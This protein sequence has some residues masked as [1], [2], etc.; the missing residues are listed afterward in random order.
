MK[1]IM[2]V[3]KKFPISLD[4]RR[5]TTNAEFYVVDGDNGNVLEITLTDDSVPVDLSDCLVLAVFSK[6]DGGVAEQDNLGNGITVDGEHNN[7]ITIELY[8]SSMSPGL[9]ECE[10]Q[11]YSGEKYGVLIT[12]A[13]FNF[14]CRRAIANRE[15]VKRTDEWPFL[16]GLMQ[17]VGLGEAE[18]NANEEIRIENENGRIGRDREFSV[19]EEFTPGKT[20]YPLNK[21]AYNGSSYIC[22][23][24]TTIAPPDANYW[25]LIAK[26]GMD[27]TGTGDMLKAEYDINEVGIVDDSQRLGGLLP[28]VY[29]FKAAQY[30]YTLTVAGWANGKYVITNSAI[31]ANSPGDIKISQYADGNEFTA[32]SSSLPQVTAQADGSVTITARGEVPKIPIRVTLEVRT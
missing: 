20:Y 26:K 3:L 8:L 16:I 6:S 18:R 28:E 25:L 2:Y 4:A 10:I 21:V 5:P 31:K 29:A 14:D 30:E 11:V 17:E 13:R 12:S 1:Y 24:E 7:R 19:W 32:F 15:V 23:E 22:V 9:V 27:G